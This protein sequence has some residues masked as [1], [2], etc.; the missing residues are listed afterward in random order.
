MRRALGGYHVGYEYKKEI[1][2]FLQSKN[3]ETKDFGNNYVYAGLGET[4]SSK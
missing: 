1:M 3:M 2:A 4:I